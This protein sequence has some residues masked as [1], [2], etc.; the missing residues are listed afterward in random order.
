[1]Q[2]AADDD[3][4]HVCT[5]NGLLLLDGLQHERNKVVLLQTTVFV[6]EGPGEEAQTVAEVNATEEQQRHNDNQDKEGH[7]FRLVAFE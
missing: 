3:W 7:Q 2:L 6:H 1:L 4:P 5:R